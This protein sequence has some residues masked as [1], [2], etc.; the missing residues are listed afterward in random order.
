VPEPLVQSEVLVACAP[1]QVGPLGSVWRLTAKRSDFYLDRVGEHEEAIHISMHGPS[2]SHPEGQRFHVKL[3]RRAA[4]SAHERGRL[5][6]HGIPPTGHAFPG[7]EIAAGVYQVARVRWTW[8][9]LRKRYHAFSISGPYPDIVESRAGAVIRRPVGV[10]E[11]IDLDVIVSTGEPYW[12][13]GERSAHDNA[14]LGPLRNDA[15]LW[16]TVTVVR[17]RQDRWPTPTALVPPRPGAGEE[18]N[19]ILSG[20]PGEDADAGMY[21]FVEAITSR[22]VVENSQEAWLA[23]LADRRVRHGASPRTDTA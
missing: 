18:P 14:R 17:R 12:P 15:G 20:G 6:A 22:R 16:M 5:A 19:R 10:N 9:I 8:D 7:K 13:G 23:T 21:W 1:D 4:A 3:D 2:S 11:A